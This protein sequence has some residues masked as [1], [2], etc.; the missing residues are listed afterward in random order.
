[1]N[2]VVLDGYAL[3]PGDL[4]WTPVQD[5]ADSFVVYDRTP[6]A[7]VVSRSR[8]AD[9]LIINKIRMTEQVLAQLPC[10]KHIVVSA[11]GVDV[12]DLRAATRCGVSVS[13]V[14]DYSSTSVA[15]MV[16]AHLL[17]VANGVEGYSEANRRGRWGRSS[18]FCYMEK[19]Q[20]ELY[21]KNF[22][23]LGLGHIGMRVAQ[24]ASAFGMQ[25]LACTSK[26]A[27]DLPAFV[28]KVSMD[29]L[30]AES[31]VLS[32][33]CPLTDATD[34]LIC[35]TNL[36]KM[37]SGAI[38]INTARGGLVNE[39]DVVE[40]LD[41]GRL[42]AYCCDVLR[43]EPPSTDN[44]LLRHPSVYATPH[45]AWATQEARQRLMDVCAGNIRAFLNRTP[46]NLVN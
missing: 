38:L 39:A 1:M 4:S 19:P 40:A 7:E 16:F 26:A 32:L 10:L 41:N 27:C 21:G 8:D 14:P 12:V 15:Q 34:G 37:K 24:V 20:R 3:N 33:H 9:I 11:T 43:K 45:I 23:I 5:L 22:G 6:E 31:D 46:Q 42:C 29:R 30:F 13:N 44:A 28:R 36:E 2:I 18:D 25:V 17:A 35:R